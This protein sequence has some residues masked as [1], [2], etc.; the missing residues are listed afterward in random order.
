MKF[1]KDEV[2]KRGTWRSSP[3]KGWW[4]ALQMVMASGIV[5][6]QR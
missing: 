2:L 6:D 3:S 5:V 1:K 4:A